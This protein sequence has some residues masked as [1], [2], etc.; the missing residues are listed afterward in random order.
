VVGI[1][2]NNRKE[3]CA[4]SEDVTRDHRCVHLAPSV[5]SLAR[6]SRLMRRRRSHVDGRRLLAGLGSAASSG[7]RG[8]RRLPA[9]GPRYRSPLDRGTA[10][11]TPDRGT[12]ATARRGNGVAATGLG[13]AATAQGHC[14]RSPS[15][16][17]PPPPAWEPP[18]PHVE[19]GEPRP[20][21]EG[22]PPRALSGNRRR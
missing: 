3:N 14:R 19:V 20:P 7:L 21:A 11:T 17:G 16:S 9:Q 5:T 1:K 13:T 2:H 15:G 4:E 8:R 12:S 22:P 18:P 6:T 10:A